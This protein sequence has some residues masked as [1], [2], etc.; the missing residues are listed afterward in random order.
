MPP[1]TPSPL[2]TY[3][4]AL[5]T[6]ARDGQLRG[7]RAVIPTE[8]TKPSPAQEIT[9][10]VSPMW[11][12]V[13]G[14]PAINFSSNDYLGLSSDERL[15]EAAIEAIR[16][17]GAGSSASRL[18][19]G[20][21]PLVLGLEQAL[22]QFKHTE[23]ALVFNSGYQANVGVLQ[24]ILEAG[25]WVFCDRLNHASL[26]DGCR[27]SGARWTRYHHLDLAHLEARLNKAPL[28]ARKWIVTDTVFSMDGD[29]PDLNALIN[30]AERHGALLM[31]DEAHATGLYGQARS[32]GLCEQF[33]VSDRI[34]LQM[35]T[36]SK[37][38]GGAGAYVAGPQVMIDT[39]INR[40]RSFIYSTALPPA[41]IAAACAA[42]TLVQSDLRPKTR[43]WNNVAHFEQ[44][45][46]AAGLADRFPHPLKSPIIPILV[47]DSAQTLKISQTLLDTG[48]FVQAIRPPTVPPGTSR[49]RIALSAAHTP[50]QIEGLIQALKVALA[51]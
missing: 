45:A 2:D 16:R 11:I 34:A 50:Q 30:I 35:G 51:T 23:A 27:L 15:K 26:M 33:G 40:A 31:V 1:S 17:Y 49:L 37:A 13:D 12:A 42:V 5:E 20:T 10:D 48:Y 18:I 3:R 21:G 36:F 39:L 22:A 46:C 29:Y 47:G 32:S 6:L 44:L 24:A 28:T 14:Q 25:D 38:L 41:V 19:S 9:P 7:C 43:L 4:Q 8:N